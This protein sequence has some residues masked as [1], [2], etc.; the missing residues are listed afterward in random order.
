MFSSERY[1]KVSNNALAEPLTKM[2]VLFETNDQVE[3]CDARLKLAKR[4][5]EFF[6]FLVGQARLSALI[7]IFE[8]TSTDSLKQR[9]KWTDKFPD[10]ESWDD[11]QRYNLYYKVKAALTLKLWYPDILFAHLNFGTWF[12]ISIALDIF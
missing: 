3:L 6:H 9:A 4:E 5:F 10:F 7:T 8:R 11:E 2:A 12:K 1:K